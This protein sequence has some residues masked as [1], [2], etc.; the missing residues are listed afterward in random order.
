MNKSHTLQYVQPSTRAAAST[1]A[2]VR[3]PRRLAR[4]AASAGVTTMRDLRPHPVPRPRRRRRS[5]G[6]RV[7]IIADTRVRSLRECTQASPDTTTV[8]FVCAPA[9]QRVRV[10]FGRRCTESVPNS[11]GTRRRPIQQLY[12]S[13]VHLHLSATTWSRSSLIHLAVCHSCCRIR[14]GS[15]HPTLD[16][17]PMAIRIPGPTADA[18]QQLAQ[19]CLHRQH[20]A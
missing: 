20:S 3:G 11:V 8:R 15:S 2:L 13:C 1:A 19:C 4:A 18:R 17:M 9:S 12:A 6:T 10:E 7:C 16:A 5:P 14:G